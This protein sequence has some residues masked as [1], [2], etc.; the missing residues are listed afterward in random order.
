MSKRWKKPCRKNSF[1]GAGQRGSRRSL[2]LR[3]LIY[4]IVIDYAYPFISR[5]KNAIFRPSWPRLGVQSRVFRLSRRKHILTGLTKTISISALK[6]T[7]II[8]RRIT[9][10]DPRISMYSGDHFPN[11]W[12]FSICLSNLK[13]LFWVFLTSR[14]QLY[15]NYSCFS[16]RELFINHYK[17]PYWPISIMKHQQVFFTLPTS[18]RYLDCLWNGQGEETVKHPIYMSQMCGMYGILSTFHLNLW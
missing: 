12:W 17:D 10:V 15:S 7:T 14:G 16:K 5:R 3:L 4:L 2:Q 13:V 11:H 8:R 1:A 6:V 9:V 18:L